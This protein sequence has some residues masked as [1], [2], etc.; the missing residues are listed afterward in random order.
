MTSDDELQRRANAPASEFV[1]ARELLSA[2]TPADLVARLRAMCISPEPDPDHAVWYCKIGDIP[3]HLLPP[4]SD[5]PMRD[6]VEAAFQRLTHRESDYIFSGWA[7]TLTE[8][9]LAV[10]ENREP[11]YEKTDWAT[12]TEAADLIERL[13]SSREQVTDAEIERLRERIDG[14]ERR[15][16]EHW[17]SVFHAAHV[18][19]LARGANKMTPELEHVGRAILRKCPSPCTQKC[20]C[21]RGSG[22]HGPEV[23]CQKCDGSG[24]VYQRILHGDA[25]A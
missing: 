16:S 9:E 22:A 15:E 11:V 12:L 7:A 4:G 1:D 18:I 23:K 2:P 21:C 3:R 14:F 24:Y 10:V 8:G 13:T 25:N 6:A 17:G 19:G 20:L 5:C